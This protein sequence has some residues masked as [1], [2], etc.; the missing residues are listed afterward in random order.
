MVEDALTAVFTGPDTLEAALHRSG[1]ATHQA[2]ITRREMRWRSEIPISEAGEAFDDAIMSEL[3]AWAD[4][5]VYT[6]VPYAGQ[7][8]LSTRWVLT[9]K[10]PDSPTSP[11]RRK[12]RLVVRGFEDPERDN[13]DS[14]A[15]TA[16]R[17][18]VRVALSSMA[19]HG[20][21]HARLTYARLSCKACPWTARILSSSNRRRTL[22]CLLVLSGSC[23]SVRAG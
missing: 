4:L 10:E 18:T 1:V 2:F 14:T 8:V 19:T 21:I 13:V 16:S 3:A 22:R 6:E 17:A 11:P 23:A 12:A 15:P 5:A 7:T 9:I 20:F